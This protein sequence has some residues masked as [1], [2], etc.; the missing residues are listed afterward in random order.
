MTIRKDSL[1]L[2]ETGVYEDRATNGPFFVMR[3]FVESEVLASFPRGSDYE[4]EDFIRWL[5]D[6]GYIARLDCTRWHITEDALRN[7]VRMPPVGAPWAQER[8]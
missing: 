5:G 3:D 1:L 4:Y 7:T 6:A 8:K 2:I